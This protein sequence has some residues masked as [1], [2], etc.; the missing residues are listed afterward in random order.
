MDA[1]RHL[2]LGILGVIPGA[3]RKLNGARPDVFGEPHGGEAR[4]ACVVESN[5]IAV[6]NAARSG[7]LG[8]HSRDLAAAMFCSGAMGAEIELA[9]Q[10]P[11]RLI[12]DQV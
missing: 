10:V 9:V 5:N 7:V 8:M 4:S 2:L 11:R 6:G 3:G 1:H 12:G